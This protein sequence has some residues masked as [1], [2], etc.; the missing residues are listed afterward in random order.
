MSVT[1]IAETSKGPAVLILAA[2]RQPRMLVHAQIQQLHLFVLAR[3]L[4]V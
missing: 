1:K 2:Q 3:V 4:L